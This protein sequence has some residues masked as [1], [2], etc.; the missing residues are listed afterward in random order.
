MGHVCL[1]RLLNTKYGSNIVTK[2]GCRVLLRFSLQKN[3]KTPKC[4]NSRIPRTPNQWNS[5]FNSG[6]AR[7]AAMRLTLPASNAGYAN[8]SC[9]PLHSVSH[10]NMMIDPT[11]TSCLFHEIAR[12]AVTKHALI[13]HPIGTKSTWGL[14][15]H[16]FLWV[17]RRG[18][19]LCFRIILCLLTLSFQVQEILFFRLHARDQSQ[20]RNSEQAGN[21]VADQE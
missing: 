8:A 9:V 12:V 2:Y 15:S 14:A 18:V 1:C 5:D 17:S 4:E 19:L 3:Q 6:C 13:R 10:K 20:A 16:G 7:N 21:D 11:G